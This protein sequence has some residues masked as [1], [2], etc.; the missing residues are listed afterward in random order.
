VAAAGD[1]RLPR[2]GTRHGSLVGCGPAFRFLPDRSPLSRRDLGRPVVLWALSEILTGSWSLATLVNLEVID[3]RPATGG[4]V[5][6][7]ESLPGA[8]RGFMVGLL[9]G[10][11]LSWRSSVLGIPMASQRL[12]ALLA[13]HGRM[14]K[15][16]TV[17][18]TLWP[19]APES[20][21]YSNLRSTLARLQ[22]AARRALSI[23]KLELGL[24]ED[25]T[26]DVHHAQAIARR[27]LDPAATPSQS[28]LSGAALAALSTDLLPDW[29]DDWILIEAEQWR[30][31]RLHALEALAGRLVGAGRLGEAAGAAG[32]A[33][34]AEPLRESGRAALIRV[35]LAEGNQSEAVREFTRYRALLDAELGLAPTPR[36]R[37][38][39]QGLQ[40][41]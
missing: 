26:V 14:V 12:L 32:A 36:L 25:V 8:E 7:S 13:L 27:L 18:G 24:V 31:L 4:S 29:Y 10:F 16:A 6:G 15:R 34:Q 22:G 33:V 37:Q 2:K 5:P 1:F 28:E 19:D 38:L 30:Q 41:P 23:S 9:G 39:V 17:A 3:L 40:G 21:A 20:H 35:H 11:T